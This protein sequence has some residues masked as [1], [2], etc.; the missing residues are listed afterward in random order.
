MNPLPSWL[1]TLL[2]LS[3]VCLAMVTG[4]R[5]QHSI[6]LTTI[7]G[8]DEV[9]CVWEDAAVTGWDA[10]TPTTD[11]PHTDPT[12]D[13][14]DLKVSWDDD[15]GEPH[16]AQLPRLPGPHLSARTKLLDGLAPASPCLRL[17]LRPP[18]PACP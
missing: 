4:A 14:D 18:E 9:A 8:C 7:D 6:V 10:E 1:R 11:V 15:W 17:P 16:F 3:I 12:Q 13:E 2:V 5:A